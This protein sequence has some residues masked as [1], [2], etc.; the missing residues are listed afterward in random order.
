MYYTNE[1]FVANQGTYY[2][3]FLVASGLYVL[4]LLLDCLG[5]F[6]GMGGGGNA[7]CVP[8]NADGVP[9]V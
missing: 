7:C 1:N 2:T 6:D 9:V 3:Y 8:C 4:Y 5:L